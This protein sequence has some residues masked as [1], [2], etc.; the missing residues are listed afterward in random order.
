[1]LER[2]IK[3]KWVAIGGQTQLAAHPE[4]AAVENP[5]ARRSPVM[6]VVKPG[7]EHDLEASP[8]KAFA[9]NLV[10]AIIPQLGSAD[11]RRTHYIARAEEARLLAEA[12]DEQQTKVVHLEMA[13]RYYRL[14]N[15]QLDRPASMRPSED[16]RRTG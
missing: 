7:L 4:P 9:R 2:D 14:A 1:M 12:A 15:F 5:F 13:A 10:N 11:E 16:L 6:S 8:Q 3:G